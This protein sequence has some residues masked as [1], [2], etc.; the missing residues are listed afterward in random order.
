VSVVAVVVVV[1]GMFFGRYGLQFGLPWWIY[2]PIP[3]L[4]TILLPPLVVTMGTRRTILCLVLAAI[5][6]P[7]IHVL[8]ALLLGWN[9]YMPFIPVP[10]QLDRVASLRGGSTVPRQRSPPL[11]ATRWGYAGVGPIVLGAS[12]W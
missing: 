9:E 8:F 3:A 5:S 6:A 10:S 7:L 1:A 2:Y 4:V 12:A 11:T